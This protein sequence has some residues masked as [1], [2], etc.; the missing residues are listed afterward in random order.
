MDRKLA[1]ILAADVVGYSAMMER[2]EAGTHQRLQQGLKDL[3]EPT[4]ARHHGNIFKL[5][6]DG[7]L[8]EFSSVVEAVECAVALQ[9]GLAERNA[10]VPEEQ[11]TVVRIGVNLG[12]VIVEG[13]DRF[14]EGVNVAARLE[15]IAEPGG[16]WVSA[17]VAR[18]VEKKLA[19]GFEVMGAQ[20]VKNLVEPVE[21]Y[22]VHMDGMLLEA[23]P[24]EPAPAPGQAPKRGLTPVIVGLVLVMAA[25]GGG[26]F[27]WQ[28]H[29]AEP[30]A[31]VAEAARPASAQP[32]A[33]QPATLKNQV[34]AVMPFANMSGDPK[35]DYFSDGMT[36]NLI[37]LLT[38]VTEL[39]VIS[40]N[41]SYAYKGKATDVRQIGKELNAGY[42]IEGSIWKDADRVR[43]TAQL[44]DA[45]T[46]EN[47]WAEKFDRTGADPLALQDEVAERIVGT[48]GGQRGVMYQNEYKF[49]WEKE[50]TQLEAYDYYL[51]SNSFFQQW[52]PAS[53]AEALRITEEGLTK[54][55][56]SGLLQCAL[57]WD[58][59]LIATYVFD[60]V[61]DEH[62]RRASE[63]LGET[64]K[65]PDLKPDERKSCLWAS[66][67]VN[68]H[69]G[70]FDQMQRAVDEVLTLAPGDA[71]LVG[72]LSC[73]ARWLG[74][75]EK[76]FERAEYGLKNDPN[77]AQYYLSLKAQALT[78]VERYAESA[79]ILQN[80]SDLTAMVPMLRA[81]NYMHLRK[82]DQAK[83]EVAKAKAM[84]PWITA[85]GWR[86]FTFHKDPAIIDRQVTDLISAGLPAK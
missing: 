10:D 37:S 84:L 25:A 61:T 41:S 32:L 82:P 8:A 12:E 38:G 9:R 31:A 51:R 6:G 1:A 21:A 53:S 59:T 81:V 48:L 75:T 56:G 78:D 27:L 85:V 63:I 14:G 54:Y 80:T 4:I 55:P 42:I 19:L 83:A 79:A 86:D 45:R 29:G 22:R 47:V 49:V 23:S 70:R 20:K 18:E 11:R 52:T 62:W 43:V 66:I 57:A 58:H 13:D 64:L 71:F 50:A 77:F 24:V 68:G 69:E 30:S 39:S 35:L 28:R 17:K 76:A 33:P 5:M 40:H 2:D 60:T 15:Q 73:A 34:I 36:D 72:D 16:I 44:I 74:Q 65:R 67:Y 7:L 46:G 3:F 26:L